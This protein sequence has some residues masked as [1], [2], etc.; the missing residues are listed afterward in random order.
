MDSLN[1]YLFTGLTGYL[2]L[3]VGIALTQALPT[4]LLTGAGAT[5]LL[6]GLGIHSA[7]RRLCA[8]HISPERTRDLQLCGVVLLLVLSTMLAV[9]SKAGLSVGAAAMAGGLAT[10]IVMTHARTSRQPGMVIFTL[11][12]GAA[13]GLAAVQGLGMHALSLATLVITIVAIAAVSWHAAK[14]PEVSVAA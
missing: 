13:S 14:D 1:R 6:A 11:L 12:V 4:P 3:V 10:G 9:S 2:L 5:L 8:H 7:S